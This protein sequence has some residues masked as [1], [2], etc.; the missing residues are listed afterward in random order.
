MARR[1]VIA[2][3]AVIVVEAVNNLD[4][5]LQAIKTKMH[6]FANTL[7][8]TG[9]LAFRAGFF[10]QIGSGLIIRE[11]ARFEDKLLD[12]QTKLSS[13]GINASKNAKEIE[14]LEGTIRLLG[15][16]TTFT[17]TE[18]AGA[19]TELSRAGLQADEIQA[20]LSGVLNLARGAGVE[21]D[22]AARVFV[23]TGRVFGGET[24][25]LVSQLI[26]T[27]R[28]GTLNLDD[29][30]QSLRY[31]SS[32]AATLGIRL[33][34]VLAVLATLADRGLVGSIGGTSFNTMLANLVK[35]GPQLEESLKGFS[36]ITDKFGKLQLIPTLERLS[37]V[38]EKLSR[39]KRVEL[40]QEIF[41]LR[42]SRA[43]ANTVGDEFQRIVEIYKS[44][45]NINRGEA[46]AARQQRE[47]GI[48]G[49]FLLLKS[50]VTE[51]AIEIGKAAKGPLVTIMRAFTE[52]TKRL[53]EFL[54]NNEAIAQMIIFSPSILLASGAA[55]L[56][57]ANAFR[58][59]AFGVGGLQ[60]ITGRASSGLGA[61]IKRAMVVEKLFKAGKSVSAMKSGTPLGLLTLLAGPAITRI[62]AGLS[63]AFSQL[64]SIF[65]N[66]SGPIKLFMTSVKL[67][68]DG[69]FEEGISAAKI[70]IG[71]LAGVIRHR[72]LAAWEAFKAGLQTFT[73]IL[74]SLFESL[75]VIFSTLASGLG[76]IGKILGF[77]SE[78]AFQAGDGPA[79]TVAKT[80]AYVVLNATQGLKGVLDWFLTNLRATFYG[81]SAMINLLPGVD[82]GITTKMA[83]DIQTSLLRGLEGR[84]A[85]R[86][87]IIDAAMARINATFSGDAAAK[88][89]AFGNISQS[90]SMEMAKISNNLE[91]LIKGPRGSGP[92]KEEFPFGEDKK[93]PI[94][95]AAAAAKLGQVIVEA[96]VGS[97]Q[98]T[99]GNVI[100]PSVTIE[101]KMLEE[102]EEQ[103][104]WLEKIFKSERGLLF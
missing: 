89:D 6:R 80:V 86:Q 19:A 79:A 48:T 20:S 2:G 11:F 57:L 40:F 67:I 43:A 35:K 68:A 36:I 70:A 47:S 76:A 16:T 94:L 54:R 45:V 27:T 42:G 83:E 53:T 59:L 98:S 49:T 87:G 56:S 41:N 71:G 85:A 50:A 60:A 14:A 64:G 101:K 97:A 4:R 75:K 81:M 30:E 23:R 3:K 32:T 12:L 61:V 13:F 46:L 10:G 99:R 63:G 90:I 28:S 55:M 66:A 103:N 29:L 7:S 102:A 38:T 37:A 104:E 52:L 82:T 22:Q 65:E 74:T 24:Q 88:A 58:I 18:V 92:L 72:L 69:Q 77:G 15:E 95:Q 8:R 17:A 96:L 31:S 73:P 93:E 39:R 84:S 25:T 26:R 33:E 9:D 100:R 21:L 91:R 44:L 62:K 5:G 34:P 1:A 51:A 78:Y